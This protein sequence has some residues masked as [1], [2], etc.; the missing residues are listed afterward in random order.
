MKRNILIILSIIFLSFN[1]SE[2]EKHLYEDKSIKCSYET[3]QG[4]LDGQY[5]SYYKTCQKKSEGTFENNYRIGKWTVWDSTGRIRMQREYSDPFTFKRIIPKVPKEKTV[6]LLNA[7]RYSIQLNQDGFIENFYVKERMVVW[8]KTILRTVLQKDNP[9]I[10]DNDKLFK[11][12][13][14]NVLAKNITAYKTK[15]DEFTNEPIINMDNSVN[16]IIGFKI[17]EVC[18]FDNERLVTETRIIGLCPIALNKKTNDP[19]DLYWVYFPDLRKYL[20]KE[21]IN[22]KDLPTKIENLDDIF[23]Y[24]Y[25]Y[26]KIYKELNINDRQFSSFMTGQERDKE[27][28]R[29]EISLIENEHDTW[30]QFTK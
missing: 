12:V 1:E 24:R 3:N 20:A 30:I 29:I 14:S 16:E 25:F 5:I 21:K 4:R 11:V 17:K 27:S 2:R 26:G 15:D 28:E 9:L 10:F 13:N 23:F 7:P 22:Q 19:F 6:E 18:F 8:S